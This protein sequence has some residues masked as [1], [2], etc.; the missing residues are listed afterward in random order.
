MMT[1]TACW[2]KSSRMAVK[3]EFVTPWGI[4]DLVG[5]SFN[6]ESVSRR[7]EL[8]QAKALRSITAAAL[9]LQIPDVETHE[10]TTLQSLTEHHAHSLAE[11]SIS[12]E[13]G[14]LVADR[15]VV[16]SSTGRLMRV[17]GWMPLHSRLVAVEMKLSRVEEA[18]R[19]ARANLGFAQESYVA[20]PSEV[21][22]RVASNI[23]RW[24]E[25]FDAGIGLL[26]I[27]PKRCHVL[28]SA[29][30]RKDLADDAIQLYCVEKFW[31]T[32]LKGN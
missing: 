19:Q 29:R 17:N 10:S 15:F 20:F 27:T 31:R 16:R 32:R 11:D 1:P 3:S 26:A 7:L 14:R 9:L 6:P 5:V 4:C 18:L 22:R 28:V 12:E 24:S 8:R 2:L 30:R 21:A 25:H 13:V 23:T